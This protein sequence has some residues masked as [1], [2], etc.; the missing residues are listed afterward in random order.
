[1][2][3][4]PLFRKPPHSGIRMSTKRTTI[5]V[6]VSAALLTGC[7]HPPYNHFRKDPPAVKKIAEGVGMGAAV[8]AATGTLM[9]GIAVGGTIGAVDSLYKNSFRATR[10]DLKKYDIQFVQY[11]ETKLLIV[12]TDR[13]F[14]FNSARLNDRCYAG[15]NTIAKFLRY[16][17][18]STFYVSG[19]TDNVGSRDHKRRLSEARAEAMVTFLWAKNITTA[20][21]LHAAGYGDDF[22]IA[23]NQLIRGS[24]MNRRIEIQWVTRQEKP[25]A[26]LSSA[27]K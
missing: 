10:A 12:P 19:F 11:G 25:V 24:A 20:R 18:Y 27:M 14:Q 17:P 8:G 13:Y 16:F 23:D 9:A 5:A 21:E 1:M 3:C 4:Q 15:L 7:F 22:P 2:N 6:I 26:N